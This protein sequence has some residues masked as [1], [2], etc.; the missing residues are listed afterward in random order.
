MRAAPR[1][2]SRITGTINAA[3]TDLL[4]HEP[5]DIAA[6][7]YC[8]I[9]H[10]SHRFMRYHA[11]K[12]LGADK[13]GADPALFREVVGNA[14]RYHDVMLGRLMSLAGTDSSVMVLSDHGF[15]SDRL[16]PDHIPA[17]A[18]GPA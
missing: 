11:G 17:E 9:D 6:V 3:A 16:L 18:A 4:E 8:G 2:F 14:Y 12:R 5:W 10:F 1:R 15:H 13:D 7:Y